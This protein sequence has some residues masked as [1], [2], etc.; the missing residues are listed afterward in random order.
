MIVTVYLERFLFSW[1]KSNVNQVTL[2]PIYQ[3][4]SKKSS[5]R[6]RSA[7]FSI[8]RTTNGDFLRNSGSW[9]Q[10]TYCRG[11]ALAMG[12][13][14]NPHVALCCSSHGFHG[15][16]M[17]FPRKLP[18]STSRLPPPPLISSHRTPLPIQFLLSGTFLT[19]LCIAN[20]YLCFSL[21]L[22]VSF[23]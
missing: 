18:H 16:E 3:V 22:E 1:L 10:E 4:L 15:P 23:P 17:I 5:L 21:N 11:R 2:V 7:T 9:E 6:Q 13:C 19:I 20:P 14:L 12:F 8:L